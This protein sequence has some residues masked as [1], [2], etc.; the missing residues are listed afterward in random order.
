VKHIRDAKTIGYKRDIEKRFIKG[1]ISRRFITKKNMKE[2]HQETGGV[3][4]ETQEN[5]TI[6]VPMGFESRISTL[7]PDVSPSNTT[8]KRDISKKKSKGDSGNRHAN[9]TCEKQ[10]IKETFQ[11]RCY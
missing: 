11:K 3:G 2:T 8:H 5:K 10:H 9:E 1:D 7:A 6:F 4:A